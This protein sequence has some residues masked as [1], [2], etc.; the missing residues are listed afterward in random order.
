VAPARSSPPCPGGPPGEEPGSDA[1]QWITEQLDRAG[2]R[3]VG[4]MGVPRVRPWS[5]VIRIPTQDGGV[6]FKAN[7]GQTTYEPALLDVLARQ[8]SRLVLDPIATDV[9]R[10]WSLLPDGGPILRSFPDDAV[11]RDW[12]RLL[13]AYAEL[14]KRL[15][16]QAEDL[17]AAGVP[18]DRPERLPE[19]LAAILDKT[20]VLLVDEPDGLSMAEL[21]RLHEHVPALAERCAVLAESGVAPT[22]DHSDLHDGNVFRRRDA[23]AVFDWGDAC[24]AHPFASLLVTM[25]AIRA[26]Y[27]LT[28]DAP[29]LTRLRDAYLEPWTGAHTRPELVDLATV[30]VAVAPVS[31]ARS[32]ER[33]LSAVP[34]SERGEHRN[35]VPGWLEELLDV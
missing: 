24:V 19:L 21:A 7:R 6:W 2:H 30:A 3:L 1:R 34:P 22:I 28:A 12:E 13:P 33:A 25:S 17:I 15:S 23:Y 29:A 8:A 20:D 35:A 4:T 18:D 10:A 16:P 9:R 32:W 14:Q 31:R 11:L 27:D 26:R 5:V